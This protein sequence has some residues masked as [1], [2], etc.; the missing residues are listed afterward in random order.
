VFIATAFYL[1]GFSIERRMHASTSR[2]YRL[3]DELRGLEDAFVDFF[4]ASK[5]S[6]RVLNAIARHRRPIGFGTVAAEVRASEAAIH[7]EEIPMNAIR[8]VVRILMFARLVRMRAGRFLITELGREVHR[9]MSPGRPWSDS[10][11]H[12]CDRRAESSRTASRTESAVSPDSNR[13][14]ADVHKRPAGLNSAGI[15]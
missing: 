3:A 5:I 4:A 12:A 15:T 2:R 9:R 14:L 8:A 1:A 13:A 7:D 6:S 11:L 10:P